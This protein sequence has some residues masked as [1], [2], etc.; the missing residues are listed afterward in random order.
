MVRA[1]ITRQN[2]DG[3]YDE[4]GTN[5][6]TLLSRKLKR[7][8]DYLVQ[9]WAD[10]YQVTYRIELYHGESIYGTPDTTYYIHPFPYE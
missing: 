3:S 6:R 7:S 10:G 2:K 1:I 4:V 5:N 9:G 8:I